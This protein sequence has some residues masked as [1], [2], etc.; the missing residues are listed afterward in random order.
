MAEKIRVHAII[1]GVCFRMETKKKANACQV[2]GW[3]KNLPD[4]TVEAVF[5]GERPSV[6][7]VVVWC[8]QGPPAAK[9]KEVMVSEQP[10]IGDWEGFYITY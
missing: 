10:F 3:V 9:V 5:E 4:G 8:H 6:E 7:E 1:S 2:C